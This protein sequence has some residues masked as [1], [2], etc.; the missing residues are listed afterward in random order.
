MAEPS[1]Y[2]LLQKMTELQVEV[3]KIH[4]RLEGIPELRKQADA[5]ED[6]ANEAK[7]LAERALAELQKEREEA[8]KA[9]KERSVNQRWWI[10]T[11]LTII[12][13]LSPIIIR[14]YF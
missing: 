9:K 2:D 13:L 14:F 6:T 7:A 1:T 11:A 10:G 5:A 12:G 4:E 3:A 8:R